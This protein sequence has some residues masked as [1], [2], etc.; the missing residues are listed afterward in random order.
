MNTMDDTH[1][2]KEGDCIDFMFPYGDRCRCTNINEL[3]GIPKH[4]DGLSP[5]EVMRAKLAKK[6]ISKRRAM[7]NQNSDGTPQVEPKEPFIR[8]TPKPPT[9][10]MMPIRFIEKEKQG[11]EDPLD[12]LDEPFPF[13][14]ETERRALLPPLPT[15]TDIHAD[16][17][18]KFVTAY[19]NLFSL[20]NLVFHAQRK[21]VPM[22]HFVLGEDAEHM[23]MCNDFQ[24]NALHCQLS[25]ISDLTWIVHD[26][27]M[28]IVFAD[29]V[30]TIPEADRPVQT[31]LRV[32]VKALAVRLIALVFVPMEKT[33]DPQSKIIPIFMA[34]VHEAQIAHCYAHDAFDKHMI[35][36]APM[37][38]VP[39]R[40]DS[41]AR[42]GWTPNNRNVFP[43]EITT[44]SSFTRHFEEEILP[45]IRMRAMYEAALK[46]IPL[47]ED[48]LIDMSGEVDF[49]EFELPAIP[50]A[51]RKVCKHLNENE[52]NTPPKDTICCKE[53][54]IDHMFNK[55]LSKNFDKVSGTKT[56]FYL[57]PEKILDMTTKKAKKV[58]SKKKKDG[59]MYVDSSESLNSV[60]DEE[61]DQVRDEQ[62]EDEEDEY[63]EDED[64]T[65]SEISEVCTDSDESSVD[66]EQFERQES[67]DG[68]LVH[69]PKSEKVSTDESSKPAEPEHGARTFSSTK[70][71][72][73]NYREYNIKTQPMFIQFN[74][75]V[76]YNGRV[77]SFPI[78]FLPTCVH[79]LLAMIDDPPTS[80]EDIQNV[81]I[82]LE[83][84]VLTTQRLK[85]TVAVAQ[86]K[87]RLLRMAKSRIRNPYEFERQRRE[88]YR[89][90]DE[91][92]DEEK[93]E[94][95][96]EIKRKKDVLFD[97]PPKERKVMYDLIKNVGVI[98]ELEKIL[99]DSR[100]EKIDKDLLDTVKKYIDQA[101]TTTGK[102]GHAETRWKPFLLVDSSRE[103][104]KKFMDL[105]DNR[106]CGYFTLRRLGITSMF[107]CR[108]IEDQEDYESMKLAN[109]RKDETEDLHGYDKC[110]DFWI[111]LTVDKITKNI[112]LHFCQRYADQHTEMVDQLWAGIRQEL[113]VINQESLLERMY[114][115]RKCE[116]LMV[117]EYKRIANFD[118]NETQ[119]SKSPTAS[120]S[121][122]SED[123]LPPSPKPPGSPRPKPQKL[124]EKDRDD[125]SELPADLYYYFAEGYFA[126]QLQTEL[127]ITIP[128]RLLETSQKLQR[129]GS[130]LASAFENMKVPLLKYSVLNRQ[131][132]FVYR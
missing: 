53:S 39:E 74:C 124:S 79:E 51:L 131:N 62:E 44:F 83:L 108:S 126:C 120:F 76:N 86:I 1:G 122:S 71:D 104:I 127:W 100:T 54:N 13:L 116:K 12:E 128:Q 7:L 123:S 89:R 78:S 113:R 43:E 55:M 28:D 80:P 16:P 26:T 75:S 29:L 84:L 111:V 117:A 10:G 36:S 57:S 67:P 129:D 119:E 107:Y 109:P 68:G 90:E 98:L 101:C 110:F 17:V 15:V 69:K 82:V 58:K 88:S 85:P 60:E 125:S 49:L 32:Y 23:T 47:N 34:T 102:Y 35:V 56:M 22:P 97:L 61:D 3:T 45:R 37:S 87:N 24:L 30:K 5:D 27:E 77:E 42:F 92:S 63:N 103:K 114:I 59:M 66:A 81:E 18:S 38:A 118:E 91:D 40:W 19:S 4:P 99:L 2:M 73:E 50:V 132:V 41:R 9:P 106:S 21:Y 105:M 72:G 65:D 52:E 70:Q 94:E 48:A 112:S 11:G 20:T 8:H 64:L 95:E 46:N 121:Q 115:T 96:D 33:F 6:K 14:N 25:E 31:H 130:P 93:T